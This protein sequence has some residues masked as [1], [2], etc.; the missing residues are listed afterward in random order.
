MLR[1]HADEI[2]DVEVV[3]RPGLGLVGGLDL[4][5]AQT[6]HVA[7]V[8]QPRAEE[9][10]L[11]P[12]PVAVAAADVDDGLHAL[13]ERD[14]RRGP[15]RYASTGARIVRE[16]HKSESVADLVQPPAQLRGVGPWQGAEAGGQDLT[17][18]HRLSDAT[19][20]RHPDQRTAP[21]D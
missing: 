20:A 8:E 4:V 6:E 15:G 17:V 5:P 18:R 14:R 12:E 2:H 9:I 16:L 10:G 21:T 3:H 11:Q 13:T 19:H 7:D 1:G